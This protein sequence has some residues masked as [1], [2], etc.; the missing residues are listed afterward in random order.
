MN[1]SPTTVTGNTT[2]PVNVGDSLSA[3]N[4]T[5]ES[6]VFVKDASTCD[7]ASFK[8]L[9]ASN[10]DGIALI[11]LTISVLT[12][13]VVAIC[14]LVVPIDA[15]GASGIPENWGEFNVA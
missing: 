13:A 11:K 14:V 5:E 3:F 2:V 9:I 7:S 12:N 8:L 10:A 6:K 4:P 1:V 15:V